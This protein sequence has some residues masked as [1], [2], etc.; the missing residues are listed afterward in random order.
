MVLV[1]VDAASS[2]AHCQCVPYPAAIAA[3][4]TNAPA[5]AE[6][7]LYVNTAMSVSYVPSDTEAQCFGGPSSFLLGT[8]QS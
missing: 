7:F 3:V 2:A 8:C 1:Y 5:P 4:S 6:A